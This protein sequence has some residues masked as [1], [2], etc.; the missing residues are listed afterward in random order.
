MTNPIE[1]QA[2]K[3]FVKWAEARGRITLTCEEAFDMKGD[4]RFISPIT[5]G[6][7]TAWQAA[8]DHVTKLTEECDNGC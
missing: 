4:H 3:E 8:W 6:L 7:W 1:Q 5:A 2:R